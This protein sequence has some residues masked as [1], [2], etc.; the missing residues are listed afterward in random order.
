MGRGHWGLLINVL[1]L[2]LDSFVRI[3]QMELLS[4]YR[5]GTYTQEKELDA[6]EPGIARIKAVQLTG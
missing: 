1:G 6:V 5:R 3:G 4:R 2:R